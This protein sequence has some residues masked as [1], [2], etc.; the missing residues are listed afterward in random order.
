VCRSNACVVSTAPS[1]PTSRRRRAVRAPGDELVHRRGDRWRSLY[2][3][4]RARTTQ[5]ARRGTV[6]QAPVLVRA[7]R[8]PSRVCPTLVTFRPGVKS[9]TL[10]PGC[11]ARVAVRGHTLRNVQEQVL[12]EA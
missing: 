10:S 6:R 11:W 4:T 3:R 12:I 5:R 8:A 1:Q 9:R 2:V 7:G